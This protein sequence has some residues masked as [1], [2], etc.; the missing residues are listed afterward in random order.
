MNKARSLEA[1]RSV[2]TGLAALAGSGVMTSP[3]NAAQTGSEWACD[4]AALGPNDV[5]LFDLMTQARRLRADW[6]AGTHDSASVTALA[7]LLVQ[8]SLTP[9]DSVHGVLSKLRSSLRDDELFD[10]TRLCIEGRMAGSIVDDIISLSA[11]F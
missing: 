5:I 1:R 4:N 9:A 3:A 6:Q 2:L 8:I 11:H 10:P 7:A